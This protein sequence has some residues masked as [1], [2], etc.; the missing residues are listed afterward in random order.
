LAQDWARIRIDSTEEM[1][2]LKDADPAAIAR[3]QTA[4]RSQLKRQQEALM[5]NQHP[6]LVLAAPGPNWARYVFRHSGGELQARAEG[7]DDEAVADLLWTHLKP[8]LRLDQPDP[9]AAWR[10]HLATLGERCRKLDALKLAGLHFVNPDSNLFVGLN[11]TSLWCGADA[12]LPDGRRF[13]PNIPTEEVFTT[14]DFRRTKGR[15]KASRPVSVMETLVHDAW[16][17]FDAGRVVRCGASS[18]QDVLERFLA[19]DEGA[20]FLGEVALVAADSPIYRSGL[21]F[22]SILYDENASCHIALGAGYPGCLAG[23][24]KLSSAA[25]QREAGCNVSMVH[26]DFMIGSPQT[27][28]FGVQADGREVPIIRQGNFVI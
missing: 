14:P 1:E 4:V 16:F 18:G 11:P 23:A 6:W 28:V 22:G 8:I 25:A 12:D 21:L 19:M 24:E 9:V 5:A 2:V 17:E 27:D 10:K 3:L 15:V 13:L 20:S 7:L 26:T